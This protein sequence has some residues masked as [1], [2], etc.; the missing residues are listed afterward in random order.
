[1]KK[2]RILSVTLSIA[3][4]M[5]AFIGCGKQEANSENSDSKK[6]VELL[7]V[8]YDPTRELYTK[9]NDSFINIGRI[10]LDKM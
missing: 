8:S 1:M 10:K 7:N 9:F 3:L 4:I 6:P 2:R 5:G